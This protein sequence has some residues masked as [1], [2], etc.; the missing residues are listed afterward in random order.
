MLQ[1]Q[2]FPF[3]SSLVFHHWQY[4]SLPIQSLRVDIQ[5]VSHPLILPAMM[6]I[7]LCMCRII[8]LKITS[9]EIELTSYDICPYTN[10]LNANC[11]GE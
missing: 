8:F 11:P 6:Q 2:Q 4:H 10:A 7:P 1:T 5:I 9:Q 3:H